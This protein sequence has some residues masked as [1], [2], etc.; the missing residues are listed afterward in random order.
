MKVLFACHR[1]P[2]PPKRGGKIRP[3]N[4]VRHLSESGHCVSVASLARSDEELEEGRGLAKYCDKLIIGRIGRF[5]ATAHMVGRLAT[6]SPSSMGYFFSGDL[7]RSVRDALQR[8]AYDLVFA[9]CSSAAQYLRAANG[10]P[11]IIDFGDMDSQKW[12][13]YGSFKP[14]PLSLGYRLEAAK[15]SQEEKRLA[16]RFDLS[17]CTT[18]AELDTLNGLSTARR[19]D[20]FPNGVDSEFFKPTDVPYDPGAIAFI[21]RMDYYPNQQ[22]MLQFC[23]TV[24]PVVQAM[25][26]GTRLTIIGADPSREVRALGKLPGV[27]VTGTVPDV[28]DYV[29]Q[30]ALT[31]APLLIARGTQNKILESM[32]MGVPVVCSSIAAKGVDAEPQ[33]HLLIADSP[34][35]YARAVTMLLDNPTARARLARA[36]RERVLSNHSWRGSMQKLDGIL[37]PFV[38]RR[39]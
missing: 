34:G 27:T 11:S 24:L 12:R 9:H 13:D 20:W 14:F 7:H 32:A 18:R 4:I 33:R 26:P 1:L 38:E 36:G 8:D 21:G 39:H 23:R 31:V 30:A 29:R 22:A 37:E 2:F 16:K 3:F 28:R 5:R 19:T 6:S 10:V 17:T 15:L 25:R 35:E